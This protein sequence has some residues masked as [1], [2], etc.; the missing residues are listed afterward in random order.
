[1]A[2]NR[3]PH[4]RW[5]GVLRRDVLPA[6]GHP[7]SAGIPSGAPRDGRLLPDEP[8][9]YTAG[10]GCAPSGPRGGPETP[11]GRRGRE[12]GDAEGKLRLPAEALRPR[13]RRHLGA[14]EL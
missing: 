13:E 9:G 6:E 3:V 7:R 2:S 14:P 4:V 12:R 1:M 8:R 11:R 5:E 10:G